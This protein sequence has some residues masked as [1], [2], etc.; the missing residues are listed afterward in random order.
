MG[1][2]TQ[3]TRIE[4]KI[5]GDRIV[6]INRFPMHPPLKTVSLANLLCKN[7][8]TTNSFMYRRPAWEDVG[9][10]REDLP[11]L[12]DWEFNIRFLNHFDVAVI[13]CP[14]AFYHTRRTTVGPTSNSVIAKVDQYEQVRSKIFNDYLRQDLA[15]G[16]IGIGVLAAIC[17]SAN[18]A[19]GNP[20]QRAF[21]VRLT[22]YI[23]RRVKQ[24][25]SGR[26]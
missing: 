1:V 2:V 8:F 25:V 3:T 16:T 26:G 17:Q 11:V 21:L 22:S 15:R 23:S 9:P 7:L 24:I 20:K 5:I 13:P 12:G 14:L 4:E 6:E 19:S 18:S 10:Y